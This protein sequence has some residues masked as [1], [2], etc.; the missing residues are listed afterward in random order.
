MA[1]AVVA[2]GIVGPLLDA[3]AAPDNA[4]PVVAR[5]G[6]PVAVP[7][8]APV[9]MRAEAIIAVAAAPAAKGFVD[10]AAGVSFDPP[11]GWI[12]EPSDALNP[13]SDPPDPAEEV[14]RFQLRMGDASLYAFPVPLTSALVRDAGAIITIGVARAGGDLLDL[15]V[16]PRADRADASPVA[17]FYQLDEERT[18][19]GLHVLTRYFIARETDRRL[20]ARAVAA[21]EDW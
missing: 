10:E 12:R 6:A 1:I 11:A 5:P 15:D 7:I 16:D 18:Y 14:V 21:E 9:T 3:A 19:E 20:V 13:Q 2:V 17:G 8:S 4:A